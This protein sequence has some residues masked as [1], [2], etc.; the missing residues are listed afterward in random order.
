MHYLPLVSREWKNGSNI[1]YNCTPIL[2]SLLTKGK[3]GS[4]RSATEPPKTQTPVPE[5]AK[6]TWR[7]MG[8]S[9]LKGSLRGSLK[10]SIRDLKEFRG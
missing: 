9:N 3:K 5:T 7:I 4:K 8:L 6:P 1:S 2:H 10:G